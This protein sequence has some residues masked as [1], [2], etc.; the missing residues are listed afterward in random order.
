MHGRACAADS[1]IVAFAAPGR[2][3]LE[4]ANEYPHSFKCVQKGRAMIIFAMT[5]T[6]AIT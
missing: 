5:M 6:H 4:G 1:C 2:I 3:D